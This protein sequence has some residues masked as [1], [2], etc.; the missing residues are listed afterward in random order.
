[1]HRAEAGQL[2]PLSSVPD[3]VVSGSSFYIECYPKPTP[4]SFPEIVLESTEERGPCIHKQ[5]NLYVA[6]EKRLKGSF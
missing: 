2:L 5:T 3:T 1:M 4:F 6:F